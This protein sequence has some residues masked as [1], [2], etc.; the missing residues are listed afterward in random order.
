MTKLLRR[1]LKSGE[2]VVGGAAVELVLWWRQPGLLS[3]YDRAQIQQEIAAFDPGEA[4]AGTLDQWAKLV[5][6]GTYPTYSEPGKPKPFVLRCDPWELKER[7]LNLPSERD[8]LLAFLGD[9]GYEFD[10]PRPLV[11]IPTSAPNPREFSEAWKRVTDRRL[12]V[13]NH[14]L[15][16]ALEGLWYRRQQFLREWTLAGTALGVGI[17]SALAER[18]PRECAEA[19]L[20]NYAFVTW[21]ATIPRILLLVSDA[22]GAILGTVHIDQLRGHGYRVCGREGCGRLLPRKSAKGHLTRFCSPR[23]RNT[24]NVRRHRAAH[25]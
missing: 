3:I 6:G 9:A 4:D 21:S 14:P 19:G 2:F 5:D 22:W 7:L 16:K 8:A 1:D 20:A 12:G 24:H 13:W 25:A 15:T 11:P 17:P 10:V 23:C 18:Y